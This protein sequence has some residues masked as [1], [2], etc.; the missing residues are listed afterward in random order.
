MADRP[1]ILI[2][3]PLEDGKKDAG[4]LEREGFD[5]LLEPML[6][7]VPLEFSSPDLSNYQAM[8]VTSANALRVFCDQVEQRDIKLYVVGQ[9][10]ADEADDL[11]FTDVVSADGTAQ[12]LVD[13]IVVRA[14]KGAASLLHICGE[15]VSFPLAQALLDQGIS[16]EGLPVYKAQ[17]VDGLSSEGIAQLKDGAIDVVVFYSKRTA[18][19][20]MRMVDENEFSEALEGIKA[21]CISSGVLECVRLYPWANTYVAPT[22]NREGM[23]ALIKGI[24]V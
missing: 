9:N 3:R 4:I 17:K 7:I 20:F 19:N 8:V 12:D 22:P 11:G 13:L 6:E 2:T 5:V 16:V 18:E 24:C 10:T 21:L 14:D 15:D 23:L 1:V